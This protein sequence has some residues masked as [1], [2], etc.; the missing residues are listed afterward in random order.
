MRALSACIPMALMPESWGESGVTIAGGEHWYTRWPVKAFLERKC[1]DYVQS[2]PVWCGGIS[3]WLKV[4]DLVCQYTGV[5]V[6]PHST[7]R[8]GSAGQAL[9]SGP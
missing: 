7:S 6:V 8:Q 5:R 9:V 3:E 4:C 2:D 1:V